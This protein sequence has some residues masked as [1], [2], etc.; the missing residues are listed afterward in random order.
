[1]TTRKT[2]RRQRPKLS[3]KKLRK[4]YRVIFGVEPKT[5]QTVVSKCPDAWEGCLRPEHYALETE[6]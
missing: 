6:E 5:N 2:G 4:R 1:M 3:Q